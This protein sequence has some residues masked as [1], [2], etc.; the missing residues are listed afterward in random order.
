MMALSGG[1]SALLLLWMNVVDMRHF[2]AALPNFDIPDFMAG[3]Y[4]SAYLASLRLA[5]NGAPD[6]AQT[7]RTMHIMADLVLPLSLSVFIALVMLC[8]LEGSTLFGCV[9]QPQH[10]RGLLVLPAVYAIVDYAE[11][12]A[13]LLYFP[14]SEPSDLQIR[15]IETVLPWLT[16]SKFMVLAIIAVLLLRH[17][18]LIR[19]SGKDTQS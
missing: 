3:G 8:F 17:V 5:L 13:S 16:A 7:L 1:L 12:A 10:I 11:N 2:Q 18:L 6:A 4:G 19:L 14:P 9:L 15:W